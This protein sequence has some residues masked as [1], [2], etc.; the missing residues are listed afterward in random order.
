MRSLGRTE[1][2]TWGITH[3][4]MDE[5]HFYSSPPPTFGDNKMGLDSSAEMKSPPLITRDMVLVKPIGLSTKY[6]ISPAIRRGFPLSR[7]TTN[8]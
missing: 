8:N 4:R 1:E 7:M 2:Q 3:T 5:G 6:R